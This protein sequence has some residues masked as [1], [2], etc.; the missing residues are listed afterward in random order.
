M[1]RYSTVNEGRQARVYCGIS[2]ISHCILARQLS[3]GS[4]RERYVCS[5]RVVF[6]KN[7]TKISLVLILER[8][9][10]IGIVIGCDTTRGCAWVGVTRPT[11]HEVSITGLSNRVILSRFREWFKLLLSTIYIWAAFQSVLFFSILH[12]FRSKVCCFFLISHTFRM[13]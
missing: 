9:L 1:Y 11:C 6:E 4:I 3:N 13:I 5:F 10:K 7:A 2:D 8:D 12:S